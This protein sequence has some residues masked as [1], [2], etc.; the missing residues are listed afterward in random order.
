VAALAFPWISTRNGTCPRAL[1]WKIW[2]AESGDS[3]AGGHM[4]VRLDK[5]KWTTIGRYGV[6]NLCFRISSF[7]EFDY[8][9]NAM[10][11][12]HCTKRKMPGS[13]CADIFKKNMTVVWMGIK[14]PIEGN[15][16]LINVQTFC[17]QHWHFFDQWGEHWNRLETRVYSVRFLIQSIPN[18]FC[19][20]GI[21]YHPSKKKYPSAFCRGGK[22]ANNFRWLA[23]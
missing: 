16:T 15:W 11:A 5:S 1:E 22:I 23:H 4:C 20:S 8:A 9:F 7:F 21:F 14:I 6:I 12:R 19:T 2:R 18:D 10:V 13:W 17:L 3:R